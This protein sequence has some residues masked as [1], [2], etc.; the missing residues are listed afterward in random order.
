MKSVSVTC[1]E[2]LMTWSTENSRPWWRWSDLCWGC[3]EPNDNT[4][5][6]MPAFDDE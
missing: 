2:C 4:L 1:P 5:G 3:M 6:P